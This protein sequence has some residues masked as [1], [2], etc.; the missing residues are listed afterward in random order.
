VV[1]LD[2]PR[3]W[4]VFDPAGAWLGT[5]STPAR[6]SVLEIGRDYV[7]GVRRDDLDVEHVQ[8]LRLRRGGG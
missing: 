3:K 7:L 4:E 8:V 6:F 5:L 2:E 1:T